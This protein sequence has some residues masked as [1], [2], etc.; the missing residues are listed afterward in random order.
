MVFILVQYSSTYHMPV[1]QLTSKFYLKNDFNFGIRRI[2]LQIFYSYLAHRQ[3]Y[4]T[5]RNGKSQLANISYEV[6]QASGLRPL[7]FIMQV[8][9]LQITLLLLR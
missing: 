2:P 8:N 7:L 5:I 9:D 6:P 3:H 4:T 1:I